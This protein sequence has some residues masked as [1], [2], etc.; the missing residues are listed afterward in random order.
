MIT[1]TELD[2]AK[3]FGFYEARA[4]NLKRP[5][6]GRHFSKWIEKDMHGDMEWLK[7][8]EDR[9]LHPEKIL[10]GAKTII[11]LIVSYRIE[12]TVDEKVSDPSCGVIARYAL[13]D[14]YHKV[15]TKKVKE[16][17][18]YLESRIENL[19]SKFYIDT[20][21]ILERD[22]ARESG[23]GFIGKNTNLIN[24]QI[25]SFVFLIEII[26]DAKLENESRN[27]IK[28]SCGGCTMCLTNC[29]T[30]AIIKDR[31]IDARKC[32]AYLTIEWKGEILEEFRKQM[33][34][35][36]FG[37]D[38]CQEVCP[39]NKKL[40]GS[41]MPEF[42]VRKEFLTPKL[43]DLAK[44]SEEEFLEMTKK[45]PVRRAGYEGFLRNVM[46]ALGNWGDKE[47]LLGIAIGL[48][49]KSKLVR[50]HAQWAEKQ[51]MI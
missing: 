34:N 36:I 13:A 20:G 16:Y 23:H 41:T 42:V 49:H 6:T 22:F 11:S 29:P 18:R 17:I 45:S 24:P 3:E 26:C 1:Q 7:R 47:A 15:L 19:K 40:T 14:D 46:I 27:E 30:G 33:K 51:L 31:E 37:C 5:K 10:P 28:E 25:G 21:P 48:K 9:R 50:H 43:N 32:L 12:E 38:I 8:D 35:R 39:W 2:K 4:I 44:L